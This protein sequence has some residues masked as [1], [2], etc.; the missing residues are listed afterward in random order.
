MRLT[1][2]YCTLPYRNFKNISGLLDHIKHLEGQI[3]DAKV[4]MTDHKRSLLYLSGAMGRKSFPISGSDLG[5]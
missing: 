1:R 3:D 5:M 2:E 4:T